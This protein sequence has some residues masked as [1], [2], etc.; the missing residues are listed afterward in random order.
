MLFFLTPQHPSPVYYDPEETFLGYQRLEYTSALQEQQQRIA[1]ERE[2]A[3]EEERHR[4]ALASLAQQEAARRRLQPLVRIAQAVPESPR[5]F[6]RQPAPEEIL[7]RRYAREHEEK[8]HS[9]QSRDQILR[10]ILGVVSEEAMEA[11]S[12]MQQGQ[13]TSPQDPSLSATSVCVLR[14]NPS[15]HGS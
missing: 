15:N 1:F 5:C 7:A 11:I 9:R 12:P 13:H 3:I 6:S 14:Y 4:R 10:Q 8:R 2:L